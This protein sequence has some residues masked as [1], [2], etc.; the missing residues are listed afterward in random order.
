MITLLPPG[1]GAPDFHARGSDGSTYR[2]ET[3]LTQTRV[4]LL[5][6]PGNDTPG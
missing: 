6:Y 1:A 4:L 5:F 3:L 2:L